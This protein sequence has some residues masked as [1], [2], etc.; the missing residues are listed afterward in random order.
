MSKL[1]T[2]TVLDLADS[3]VSTITS[4]EDRERQVAAASG[5]LMS[6]G[7]GVLRDPTIIGSPAPANTNFK[8]VPVLGKINI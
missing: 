4:Q 5:F 7:A 8:S 3:L 1:P 6:F 2:D